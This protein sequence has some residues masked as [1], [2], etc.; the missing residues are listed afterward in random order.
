MKHY[1]SIWLLCC[2]CALVFFGS[3]EG[4]HAM[5]EEESCD[6]ETPVFLSDGAFRTASGLTYTCN[7]P[8]W[9]VSE[10]TYEYLTYVVPSPVRSV[11]IDVSKWQGN[12]DWEKVK[13]CGI[14]FAFIRVGGRGSDNGLIE[15]DPY[16]RQNIQNAKA[17]GLQVGVYIFSQATTV[18]EAREEAAFVLHRVEGYELDLPIVMDYEFRSNGRL[19]QAYDSKRLN[20]QSATEVCL[21]FCDLVEEY[22]YASMVYANQN[23]LTVYLDGERLSKETE[24][25][26]ARY[27]TSNAY[28]HAYSFWQFTSKAYVE[29]VESDHVDLNFRFTDKVYPSGGGFFPFIDAKEGDWYYDA[30]KYTYDNN[31]FNGAEWDEFAPY[32]E[33]TRAMMVSVLYRMAGS[34]AVSGS[35]KFKDLTLDWYKDAVLWGEKT[36]VVSGTSATTFDPEL[37]LTREEM[38]TFLY[39]YAAYKGQN[40]SAAGNLDRFPDGNQTSDWALNAMKWAVGSSCIEGFEDGRLLPLNT[41]NRAEV[42]TILMKFSE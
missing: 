30:V 21:A 3:A 37:P 33:M 7:N 29:G 36:G 17:A 34:P 24:V 41:T 5:G 8:I 35:S 31:L 1:K 22:G 13:A 16:F 10:N 40:V 11:G 28:G 23:M 42:A 6:Y 25:W 19:N 9:N 27:N 20:A 38:V 32:E 2:L 39:R 18:E 26:L 12:I 4:V 14:D 15:E